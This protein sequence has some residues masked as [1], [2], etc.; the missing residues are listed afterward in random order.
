MSTDPKTF[1]KIKSNVAGS[2][3]QND[4]LINHR[5]EVGST[6]FSVLTLP[7]VYTERLFTKK[8][9]R[10]KSSGQAKNRTVIMSPRKILALILP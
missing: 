9:N 7:I 6:S 3:T 2:V 1:K 5:P 10:T 4:F 8:R